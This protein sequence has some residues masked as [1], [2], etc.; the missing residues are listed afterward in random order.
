MLFLGNADPSTHGDFVTDDKV[1]WTGSGGTFSI[2]KDMKSGTVDATLSGLAGNS[3]S[4]VR[5]KGSWR[6]AA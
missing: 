6:C 4:T 1:F 3:G 2:A 5:I